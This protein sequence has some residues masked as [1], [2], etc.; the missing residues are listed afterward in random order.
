MDQLFYI[1]ASTVQV[2]ISALMMM[3]L[4]RSILGLFADDDSKALIFCSIVTEP[5]VHPVR[6]LLTKIPAL[7][8]SPI[9]F[10]YMATYLVL[11]IV[12]YALPV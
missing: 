6:S 5:V 7:Q 8:D 10:S 3:V 2:F 12:Q 4:F 11:I 1:I 9:D